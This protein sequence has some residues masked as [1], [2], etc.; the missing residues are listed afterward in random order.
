MRRQ[1]GQDRAGGELPAHDAVRR[2]QVVHHDEGHLRIEAVHRRHVVGRV[3]RLLAQ[4][5]RLE[6]RA[7]LQRKGQRV[8]TSGVCARAERACSRSAS[9]T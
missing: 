2:R 4:R 9:A 5:L 3:A 1:L 7:L 6:P 8:W